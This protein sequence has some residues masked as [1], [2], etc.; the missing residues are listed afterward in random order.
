VAHRLSHAFQAVE[1]AHGGQDMGR[2]GTLVPTR[3]EQPMSVE[4]REHRLKEQLR[5]LPSQQAGAKFA[6]DGESKTGMAE[7]SIQRVFPVNASAHGLGGLPI[8]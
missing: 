1:G 5:A 4:L 7:F 3:F 2:I 6:Q 8:R